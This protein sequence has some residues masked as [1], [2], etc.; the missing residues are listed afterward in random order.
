MILLVSVRRA[1]FVLVQIPSVLKRLS[2]VAALALPL[3]PNAQSAPLPP[4]SLPGQTQPW[5][6]VVTYAQ[7]HAIPVQGID[8]LLADGNGAPG[9]ALTMLITF[10]SAPFQ[11]QWLV[12]LHRAVPGENEK[13]EHPPKAILLKS[14]IS[15]QTL[16]FGSG[17]KVAID[18]RSVGPFTKGGKEAPA[19]R[20][21]RSFLAP[22]LMAMG[23]DGSC[24]T[25]L[26]QAAE[27]A[28][29]SRA[30]GASSKPSP[31]FSDTE[32][33][34]AYGALLALQE[35]LQGILSSQEVVDILWKVAD[36]PSG[37]SVFLRGGGIVG[38]IDNDGD[39]ITVDAAA[40]GQSAATLYGLPIA[41][42]LNGRPALRCM[43]VVGPP[44]PPFS[45]SAGILAISAEP[46]TAKDKRMEM[47]IVSAHRGAN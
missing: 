20:R 30:S 14:A 8:S 21:G 11:Q 4:P 15:G 22:D 19:D 46:A 42:R 39:P 38:E 17:A 3:L 37:L 24:R 29:A 36:K 13:A 6:E 2:C 1:L 18:I 10:S 25:A 12:E 16:E 45:I 44:E 47:R 35:F 34:E 32:E 43:L 7:A 23:L 41:V 40:W 26:R 27:Q 33:R 31:K 5:N 9:D 28:V